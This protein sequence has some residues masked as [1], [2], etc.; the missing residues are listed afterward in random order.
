[1]PNLKKQKR[2][3]RVIEYLQLQLK[4][5][6]K[7]DYN[8]KNPHVDDEDKLIDLSEKDISRIERELES[9]T[10]PRS[11]K[12]LITN[13]TQPVDKW[14]ID[15]FAIKYGYVKQSERRK[16]KGKSKKKMKRVKSSSFLKSVIAQPGMITAYKD[17]RMGLSPKQHSFRL[18]KEDLSVF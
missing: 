13:S 8:L 11:K 1:M 2:Q 14:Y 12:K 4:T 17:G 18:R 5:G 10:N 15:I 6:K 9:L 16:N 7:I 3:Q